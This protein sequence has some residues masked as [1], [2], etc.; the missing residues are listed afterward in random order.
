MHKEPESTVESMKKILAATICGVAA[1]VVSARLAPAQS[2]TTMPSNP[3]AASQG[4]KAPNP[5]PMSTVAPSD[6]AVAPSGTDD[7][8]ARRRQGRSLSASAATGRRSAEGLNLPHLCFQ[9]GIGWTAVPAAAFTPGTDPNDNPSDS[10]KPGAS[11]SQQ[12]SRGLYSVSKSGASGEC[13]PTPLPQPASPGT[14]D[15]GIREDSYLELKNSLL[16]PNPGQSSDKSIRPFSGAGKN[17]LAKP[18]LELPGGLKSNGSYDSIDPSAALGQ[19]KVLRHRAYISPV[20]LRRLSRNMQNLET[21]LELRQMNADVQKRKTGR[22]AEDQNKGTGS[23]HASEHKPLSSHDLLAKQAEC[24]R[25][26]NASKS[27]VCALLKH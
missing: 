23:V 19:L 18:T 1:F 7:R 10:D 22:T 17:P 4:Q 25:T 6:I 2:P 26:G 14:N 24:N 16:T 11:H 15:E 27:K 12:V 9:P 21:R 20:K 13:P 8:P 5:S 3:L